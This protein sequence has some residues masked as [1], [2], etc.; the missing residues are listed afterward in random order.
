[1]N[2]AH[3]QS[4]HL[5]VIE[6]TRR[7]YFLLYSGYMWQVYLQFWLKT[8][9][10][11]IVMDFEIRRFR[12]PTM[13]QLHLP[14]NFWNVIWGMQRPGAGGLGKHLHA[15]VWMAAGCSQQTQLQLMSGN[16]QVTW[17]SLQCGGPPHH[18]CSEPKIR[19]SKRSYMETAAAL[20]STL[21]NQMPYSPCQTQVT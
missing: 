20:E 11:V 17:A 6:M 8:S 5:A 4:Q 15:N 9:H 18:G 12:K 7:F 1:M 3:V 14:H 16:L 2:P 21:N 10:L 13:G 19:E